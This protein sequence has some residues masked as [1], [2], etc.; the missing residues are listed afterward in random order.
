MERTWI[1]LGFGAVCGLTIGF[2]VCIAF[3]GVA[4]LAP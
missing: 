4:R 1:G 2:G 3:N